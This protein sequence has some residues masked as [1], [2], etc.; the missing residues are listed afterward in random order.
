MRY[1][2]E[3]ATGRRGTSMNIV[4]CSRNLVKSKQQNHQQRTLSPHT[5]SSRFSMMKAEIRPNEF[6]F[7][8]TVEARRLRYVS[9]SFIEFLFRL[10]L[11]NNVKLHQ[12]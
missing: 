12:N 8:V 10:M 3:F 5:V 6:C 2:G 4:L 9:F 1:V 11:L 7:G